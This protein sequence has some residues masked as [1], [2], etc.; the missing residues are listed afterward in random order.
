MENESA[1][2][3]VKGVPSYGG[4]YVQYNV[5]G[6]LFEVSAKYVP[7]IQPV[8]RGAYGIVW[9]D[10]LGFLFFGLLDS[11]VL[12]WLA[13]W[14][15]FSFFLRAV[16]GFFFL[17]FFGAFISMKKYLENILCFPRIE[18]CRR[19]LGSVWFLRKW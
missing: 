10:F 4:K 8:G 13:F 2:V 3:E 18:R 6:N 11:K 5:L 19:Y 17:F 16:T 9:W 14:K 12:F 1:A 7:P 15:C